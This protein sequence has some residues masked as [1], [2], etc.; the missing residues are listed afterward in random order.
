MRHRGV[1]VGSS[2][3]SSLEQVDDAPAGTPGRLRW[4]WLLLALAVALLALIARGAWEGRTAALQCALA[5]RDEAVRRAEDPELAIGVVEAANAETEEW[6]ASE[7]GKVYANVT[8]AELAAAARWRRHAAPDAPE[9]T[10]AQP[11][12]QPL[13]QDILG[14]AAAVAR[15][16]LL[17]HT[18]ASRTAYLA[19][20]AFHSTGL[21]GNTLSLP[22]TAL[23][24]QGT[25]LLAGYHPAVLH[26]PAVD[27]SVAEVLGTALLWSGLLLADLPGRGVPPA[28]DLASL[29]LTG[30]AGLNSAI[31]RGTGTPTGLRQIPVYIVRK[32]VLLPQPQEVPELVHEFLAW[33]VREASGAPL[34]PPGPPQR[35]PQLEAA[36]AL[37]CNAHTRFMYIHP[38][39]DGN[40][41]TARTLSALALQR[42]GLPA[43]MF[44]RRQRREYIAAVSSATIGRD[45]APLALLHARAV[46]RS[47]A[48]LLLLADQGRGGSSG[49]PPDMVARGDCDLAPE[50]Y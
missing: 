48:C 32:R 24:V 8:P 31:T 40:G 37:A 46:L 1:S 2:A 4:G 6:R 42:A 36:L 47:L 21:E 22:Q 9:R 45:Y 34:Q 11:L 16:P 3:T 23:T 28:L 43:P 13:L 26:T 5:E 41:R 17:L 10:C 14:L 18:N 7:V 30:L 35:A 20:H 39:A 44:T 38:F 25:P 19:L 49:A 29:R 27:R 12:P 33:L 15:L 50:A